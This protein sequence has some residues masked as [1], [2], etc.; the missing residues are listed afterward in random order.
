MI[1]IL[2]IFTRAARWHI[3][4]GSM[5]VAARLALRNESGAQLVY[6]SDNVNGRALHAYVT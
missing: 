3:S 2:Q 5:H 1:I 6:Q 4:D